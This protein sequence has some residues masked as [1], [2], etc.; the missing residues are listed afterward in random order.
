MGTK[1]IYM[2][3]ERKKRLDLTKNILIEEKEIEHEKA[4]AL[5]S[6]RLGVNTKRAAEY[7]NVLA[8]LGLINL[9]KGMI[10]S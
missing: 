1:G 2:V 5:I 9:D 8:A 3:E 4:V 7:I 10:I 6:Y